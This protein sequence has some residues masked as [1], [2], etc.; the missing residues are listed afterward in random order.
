ML[1]LSFEVIPSSVVEDFIDLPPKELAQKLALDK[2]MDVAKKLSGENALIIGAD[3]IVVVG[4]EVLGKPRDDWEAYTMLKKIEGKI[5]KVITGIALV[6]AMDF[7]Y[8]T[9]FQETTVKIKKL[10]DKKILNY[11]KT[12][13]TNDKAG[14]YAIQGIGSVIVEEIHGCYFNVVGLPISKLSDMLEEWGI[15]ILG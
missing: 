5:H 9:D 13:E 8:K 2:A 10:D 14:A 12:G 11:I 3:T 6:D 15:S 4:D 1:G 7:K